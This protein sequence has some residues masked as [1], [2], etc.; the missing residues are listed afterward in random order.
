MFVDET[1]TGQTTMY[2][3]YKYSTLF[4][5]DEWMKLIKYFYKDTWN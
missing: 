4:I 2:V 3:Y 1:C 5:I